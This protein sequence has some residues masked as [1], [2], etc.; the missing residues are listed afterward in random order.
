MILDIENNL[1]K[2]V[3]INNTYKSPESK[4]EHELDN[5]DRMYLIDKKMDNDIINNIY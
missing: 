5:N 2:Y 4:K 1:K 3:G